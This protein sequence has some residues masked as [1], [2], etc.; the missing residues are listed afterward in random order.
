MHERRDTL[1]IV[2]FCVALAWAF[3]AWLIAP[4]YY[5]HLYPSVGVH[6]SL[7]LGVSL[8]L[9]AA[10]VYYLKI[11]DKLPDRLGPL[12]AGHYL[13]QDGLCFM[14]LVR[15]RE[16]GQGH[17]LAEISLY[18]Q[19][20]YSN[21]CEAVIHLRPVQQAFYSH[22]GARDVH[23]AFRCLGGEFGV[24]H[25]PVA[26]P[27]EFEG[28]GVEVLVGAAVRYPKTHGSVLRSRRGEPCGTF[29]VDWEKAYRQSRH[30]LG[31]EIELKNPAKIHLAMPERVAHSLTRSEFVVETLDAPEVKRA[32]G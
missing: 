9:L 17:L 26:V 15:V 23:F 21:E 25:Q 20:R 12:T 13:E 29:H 16:D 7:S 10:L 14:P 31:G 8:V 11:Q 1:V 27:A 2:C 6:Q 22:K 30:E 24:V 18:Y 4:D 3:F 32:V 19:N 28:E 5:K